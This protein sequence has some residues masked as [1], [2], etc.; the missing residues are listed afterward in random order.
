MATASPSPRRTVDRIHGYGGGVYADANERNVL[1]VN[2][3]R[4][5]GGRSDRPHRLGHRSDRKEIN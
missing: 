2:P 5:S 1:D 3:R 4:G